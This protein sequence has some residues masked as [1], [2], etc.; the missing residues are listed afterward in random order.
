MNPI[1]VVTCHSLFMMEFYSVVASS[2][3]FDGGSKMPLY[4]NSG[5]ARYRITYNT[6][7][8]GDRVEEVRCE[9]VSC[10]KH[11]EDKDESYQGCYGGCC[12]E[13]SVGL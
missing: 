7:D 9:V 12:S 2:E 10:A 5:L 6:D 3:E 8:G 4:H 11:L 1:I 13:T